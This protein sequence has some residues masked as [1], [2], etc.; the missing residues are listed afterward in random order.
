MDPTLK[1]TKELISKQSI[2]PSDEGCQE[3]IAE[4]LEAINFR[5]EHKLGCSDLASINRR[6]LNRQLAVNW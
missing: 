5:I 1:L 3:L 4:R 2:T 6:S